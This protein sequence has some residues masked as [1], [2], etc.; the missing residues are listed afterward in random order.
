MERVAIIPAALVIC[1]E[2]VACAAAER[3]FLTY[4]GDAESLRRSLAGVLGRDLTALAAEL[5]PGERDSEAN[6]AALRAV[7]QLIALS[8]VS[9]DRQAH[10]RA[11][12]ILT[13]VSGSFL[14]LGDDALRGRIT[15]RGA[16]DSPNRLM[17]D[18]A[19]DLARLYHLTGDAGAAHRTAVILARLA[20]VMPT[21]PLVTREGETRDQDDAVYRNAWDANGLWGGWFWSDISQGVPALRA[22]DLI[23]NS[24]AMQELGVLERIERDLLRHNVEHYFERPMGLGNLLHYV[25]RSLPLYGKAIPEPE[26]IHRTMHLYRC[27]IQSQY[28]A[29]GFWHEGSPAYHKDITVGLTQQVPA[30]L[31]G[32]SDPPGYTC[33]IDRQRYDNLDLSAEF[34][35]RHERMWDALK[36]LTFPNQ[37]YA[38]LHDATFPHRAWWDRRPTQSCPRLLGCMGHAILGTNADPDQAQLHLHYS[39][40]HGHEHYDALSII[41]FARGMELLSETKYRVPVDW[42]STR[43][44]QTM[45]AGHNTVVID[46]RNQLGRFPHASHR[47]PITEADAMDGIPNWRYRSGGHGDALNDPKLRSFVPDWD[48]VQLAEAEAERAYHP[49]PEL[50]RR[51]VALVRVDDSQVYA[52]DV[53]RVRGGQTHDWMLHGCLQLPYSLSVTEPL[54]PMAGTLH[55][56]LEQLRSGVTDA[57]WTATFAYGSGVGLRTHMLGQPGSQLI[58]ARGPAMRRRGYADFLDVRRTGGASCFAAIHDP[59]QGTPNVT[60]VHR[61]DWGG[62]M[63]VGVRVEL[64]NGVT[65][66]VLSSVA[67]PPFEPFVTPE[68]ILFAGRFA[69]IRFRGE[70]LWHAY[71]VDATRLKVA[72]VDVRGQGGYEGEIVRTHRTEAGAAFDAF[73][74]GTALPAGL[75]GRCLV[76]DLGGTLTQAFVIAHVEPTATGS[77]IYSKD[78]PGIEIRG[79]LIKMIYY[80][81]WGIPRPCRFHIADTLLWQRAGADASR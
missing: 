43:E 73:E 10:D 11:V 62:D 61:I 37:D 71:A 16:L 78:E 34:A 31:K 6:A 79:D 54:A 51:T 81:G 64:A 70:R 67:D 49:D 4:D 68:G 19:Y 20:E 32:Y 5:V 63:D 46:E 2:V 45:T 8:A 53:F 22:F 77:M 60:G 74:T 21:W 36:T 33:N 12:T 57:A 23:H 40:T 76:L 26:Y 66:V 50:Y 55:K 65:D 25:L 35:R 28:Y 69:H 7:D 15:E 47:R 13:T 27:V 1:L 24:G 38:K 18:V 14:R 72:D 75:A 80:P 52:V 59:Y 56:F 29:D 48:P 58:V 44:W 3:P 9:G 17:R 41:L 39:G 42:E 30:V